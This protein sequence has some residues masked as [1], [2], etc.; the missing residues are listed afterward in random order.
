MTLTEKLNRPASGDELLVIGFG[1]LGFGVLYRL[2]W[3]QLGGFMLF[4][5]GIL[6]LKPIKADE[7]EGGGQQGKGEGPEN[8]L[9]RPPS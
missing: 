1:M 3:V 7:D 5:A 9:D 8:P 2:Y 6:T 4:F